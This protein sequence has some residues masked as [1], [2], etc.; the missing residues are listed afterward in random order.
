MEENKPRFP[1]QLRV[2]STR[3]L[4]VDTRTGETVRDYSQSIED[5]GRAQ[6]ER[7]AANAAHRSEHGID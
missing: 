4:L 6:Y 1:F 5:L 3:W 2:S 7:D